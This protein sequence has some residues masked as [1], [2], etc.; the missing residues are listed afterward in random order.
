MSKRK[1]NNPRRRME[2]LGKAV[3]KGCAISYI[4]GDGGLCKMVD[5]K[6][7]RSFKPGPAI[8]KTIEAG[9][10]SWSIICAVFCRDQTGKEYMKSIVIKS[11]EPR[12]QDELL[13]VLHDNHKNLLGECN[14]AHTV[15]VGWLASPVGHEWTEKEAGDIF[16]KLNAWDFVAKW[17]QAA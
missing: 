15:S 14:A 9:R 13:D 3:L 1:A 17:E 10:Y 16:T 4:G 12:Q 7:Q 5:I 6:T 8:A 11:T 2:R